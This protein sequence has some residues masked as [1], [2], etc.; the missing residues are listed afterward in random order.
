MNGAASPCLTESR[1]LLAHNPRIALG[2]RGV[3]GVSSAAASALVSF[4]LARLNR[5]ESFVA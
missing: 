3:G 2:R 1:P 4:F 5:L